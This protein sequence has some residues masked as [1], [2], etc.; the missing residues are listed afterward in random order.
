MTSPRPAATSALVPGHTL[1]AE[2]KPYQQT[3]GYAG[4]PVWTRVTT[5]RR[6]HALC[7]CGTTS[8]ELPSTGQRKQW[9]RQHKARVTT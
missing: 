8:D 4:T 2:G 5:S 7:S 9:H 3:P 1:V 6:G